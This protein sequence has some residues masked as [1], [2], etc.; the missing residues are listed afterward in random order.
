[1]MARPRLVVVTAVVNL[2]GR[3]RENGGRAP[4]GVVYIGGK[5]TQGGWRLAATKWANPWRPGRDGTRAEVLTRYREYVRAS[6]QLRA[7]L[8][9]L[10]G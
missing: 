4:A 5:V 9:E 1:M 6:P 2:H 8:P 10:R 3:V 7:A